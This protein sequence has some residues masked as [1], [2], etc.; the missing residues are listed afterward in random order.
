MSRLAANLAGPVLL[1]TTR[2]EDKRLARGVTYEPPTILERRNW[3]PADGAGIANAAALITK[4]SGLPS[5]CD[6]GHIAVTFQGCT[7]GFIPI[8]VRREDTTRGFLLV[9]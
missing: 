2:R 6:Y 7:V 3:T 8:L 4:V 1:W 9:I 5:R